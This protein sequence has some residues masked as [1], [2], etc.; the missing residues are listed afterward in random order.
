MSSIDNIEVLKNLRFLIEH[1]KSDY[2]RREYEELMRRFLRDNSPR[3]EQSIE[4]SIQ[5]KEKRLAERD[6]KQAAEKAAEEAAEAPDWR[7]KYLDRLAYITNHF[8][9]ETIH[10]KH[11]IMTREPDNQEFITKLTT[12]Y[13]M[14]LWVQGVMTGELDNRV[15]KHRKDGDLYSK[16]K[17]HIADGVKIASTKLK[18]KK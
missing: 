12:E 18:N 8:M 2:S 15:E 4:I 3:L 14:L 17:V 5:E 7:N 1:T 10:K 6:A 9:P 16:K 11:E 13:D